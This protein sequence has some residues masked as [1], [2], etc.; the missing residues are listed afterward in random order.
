MSLYSIGGR[1]VP[2]SSKLGSVSPALVCLADGVTLTL[3][4]VVPPMSFCSTTSPSLYFDLRPRYSRY[5]EYWDSVSDV[6][7]V[8]RLWPVLLSDGDLLTSTGCCGIEDVE[9]AL[10]HSCLKASSGVSLFLASH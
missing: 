3:T 4:L 8:P 7:R 2:E 6:G 5:I 9:D 10:S 1:K